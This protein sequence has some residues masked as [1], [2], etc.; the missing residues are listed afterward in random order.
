LYYGEV[1]SHADEYQ[2]CRKATKLRTVT[3][4]MKISIN[5]LRKA[6]TGNVIPAKAGIQDEKAGFPPAR[7]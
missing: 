7:E 4:G 3:N 5:V 6:K 2:E 1:Y